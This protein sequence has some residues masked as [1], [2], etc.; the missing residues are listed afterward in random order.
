M[1]R[2]VAVD[3]IDI[4]PPN[5]QYF[6]GD[7]SIVYGG[8]V[9]W[10]ECGTWATWPNSRWSPGIGPAQLDLTATA[11][12]KVVLPGNAGTATLTISASASGFIKHGGVASATITTSAEATGNCIY[13]GNASASMTVSATVDPRVFGA[14]NPNTTYVVE[15]ETRV[16]PVLGD[17]G[18]ANLHRIFTIEYGE[19]RH[20]DVLKENGVDNTVRTYTIESETRNLPTEVY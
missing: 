14:P 4:T 6:E 18:H 17:S 20:Y 11:V 8:S 12:G 7:Q 10:D 13:D 9:A 2:Y 19:S 16:Y 5:G 15:S 1:S 3:Y